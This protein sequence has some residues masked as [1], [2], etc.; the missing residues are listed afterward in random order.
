MQPSESRVVCLQNSGV[1]CVGF[2]S[3]LCL[4]SASCRCYRSY[5]GRL[6]YLPK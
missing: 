2:L 1:A 3:D 4:F 5:T 6:H